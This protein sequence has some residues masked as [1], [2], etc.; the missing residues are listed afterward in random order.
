MDEIPGLLLSLCC[1]EESERGFPGAIYVPWGRIEQVNHRGEP[2]NVKAER[3]GTHPGVSYVVGSS[4]ES[5]L[6]REGS[7]K[8]PAGEAYASG[9]CP[10]T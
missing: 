7:L 4:V 3:P 9:T 10:V 2:G 8:L 1:K 6:F 5:V